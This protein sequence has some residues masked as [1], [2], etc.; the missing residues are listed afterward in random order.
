MRTESFTQAHA[1]LDPPRGLIERIRR[2]TEAAELAL[3]HG[4]LQRD[5]FER[6][7]GLLVFAAIATVRSECARTGT[8]PAQLLADE[9]QDNL[10]L[11]VAQLKVTRTKVARLHFAAL[12]E[13]AEM[14]LDSP[15]A[16]CPH[17]SDLEV[18]ERPEVL[19]DGRWRTIID[20]DQIDGQAVL[21]AAGGDTLI[22]PRHLRGRIW[23][24]AGRVPS[25]APLRAPQAV[26]R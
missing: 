6:T 21:I 3:R 19:H 23:V 9:H 14:V 24:R 13:R 2:D 18:S 12:L 5:A 4:L 10:A 16:T 11:L 26:A 15:D 17:V 1:Q 8:T 20:V 22:P 7:C 25:A